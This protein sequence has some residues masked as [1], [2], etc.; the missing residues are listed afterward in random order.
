MLFA[1]FEREWGVEYAFRGEGS[2]TLPPADTS[3]SGRRALVYSAYNDLH[4]LCDVICNPFGDE[5]ATWPTDMT[6][7]FKDYTY[8]PALVD[9]IYRS[10]H[11]NAC[12]GTWPEAGALRCCDAIKDGYPAVVGLGY[13]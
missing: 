13:L 1:W 10:W 4:E 3:T 12:T 8:T 7:G 2:N 11:I 5:G 6:D 9:Q